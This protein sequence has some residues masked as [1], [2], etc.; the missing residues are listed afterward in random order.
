MPTLDL[1][2]QRELLALLSPLLQTEDER[3]ALLQLT[4]GPGHALLGR[5]DFSGAAE[6]F[7][8]KLIERLSAFG[9]LEPGKQ[10]LWAV[11]EI[12]RDRVGFDQQARIDALRA[13][14]NAP[15]A[16]LAAPVQRPPASVPRHLRVFLASPG[17][18]A[19]ERALAL[20]V[21]DELQYDPLLRGG[22]TVETVAWDKPGA[23]T[24]MLA[25]MTPQEA[26]AEGLP[27]PS[28][29]DI[30]VVTLWSR[31]GTP[32]PTD[33]VKSDGTPYRSATEWE[34][35]DA[36]QAAERTGKPDI[37]VYRRTEEL[38]LGTSDPKF[39][40]K[41][42]QWQQVE[43][44]FAEFRNPDGSIRRGYNGY[45]TPDAFERTLNLHLRERVRGFLEAAEPMAA[46]APVPPPAAA[47][48]PLWPDSPFPGLRAFTPDDAPI[49]FGRGAETDGLVQKLTDPGVRFL[50]VVGASGS[51]KSSLVAAGLLPR[52]KA[53][54][55]EGSKDSVLPWVQP[56]AVGKGQE[57]VG[58]RFTPAEISDNPF[59]ALAV[60]LAP[61]V[62]YQPR[63]LCERLEAAPQA[64]ADALES[65][66]AERP[67]WAEVLLFVDQ[68]E[69]LFTRVKPHY[70]APFVERLGEA[71]RAARVRV[72]VTLRGDFYGYCVEYPKLAERL[73][74]GSY[75]LAA[76][77]FAALFEMITAPANRAGLTFQEGLPLQILEDTGTAPGALALMGFALSELYLRR[78][79]AGQ[80]TRTAYE[81]FG[82][83]RGAIGMQAKATF[84]GLDDEAQAAFGEVFRE[85]VQVDDRGVATR[86]RASRA[87]LGK[88]AA[89]DRLVAALIEARLLV[90]SR[91]ER[92][93][94]LVEV[95]HEALF[96][97]W[98][99]L[100]DWIEMRRDDLRLLR[101]L[102]TAA[103]EWESQ[104]R[105][106]AFLWSDERVLGVIG[107]LARLQPPLT[108]VERDFLGPTDTK[109][110][111]AV[112]GHRG[113]THEQRDQIGVRLA[114]LDDLR[115][116]VR[117][118]S[119]GI[120]EIEWCS[121]PGGE[122]VLAAE[123]KAR[124]DTD[125]P[126]TFSVAPFQM[127]KYPITVAQ[128]QAF[129]TAPD[130][131]RRHFK[132]E[133]GR[134]VE[135]GNYP[136]VNVAW[137]EAMAFCVWLT[138]Q[139]GYEVRLATEWE[140]QQAASS[141]HPEN[142]YPWGPEWIE[143]VANTVESELGRAIAVGLYP[144]G[145]S[146]QGVFD[147]AGNIWEWCLNKYDDPTDTDLGGE[148]SRVVRGGAWDRL[149]DFARASLR[150]YLFHP[151]D[152]LFNIGFRVVCLP[153]LP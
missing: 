58:L 13:V 143:G 60:R 30:V 109:Q 48:L 9:E 36:L 39:L 70:R 71:I 110:M 46:P 111:L 97:A 40:E 141:G 136:A 19:D 142:H 125:G 82:G 114:L 77:G 62:Q 145:A 81:A 78:T 84:E 101:Q 49:F 37:L 51:G 33:W 124:P 94:A 116:G 89:A 86:Q 138:E 69:E 153:H 152:R 148:D 65:L 85:L 35:R 91:G 59:Q 121:I 79:D 131:H 41:Y 20:K 119:E 127:A 130:G 137:L 99:Q 50:A 126:Y 108:V 123:E 67:S 93:E 92:D 95:A 90:G 11:L 32:L 72:V 129:V 16:P 8:L 144:Q 88:S 112:L 151:F 147:L 42:A 105:P 150:S 133:P 4:V 107:M 28:E 63:A 34:Y 139:L 104:K 68:F 74:A 21:L 120:P 24:P 132:V 122:V 117:L 5:I 57:W 66:L 73:R 22:A 102:R 118:T 134:Q 10:A 83:V 56:S 43:A 98:P 3:R 38:N 47:P 1:T 54:A 17:D 55:I 45:P 23:G 29:C 103:A 7:V 12:A 52:L 27:K 149:Q 53:N 140:W 25:T 128:Y 113:T 61:L 80:L 31:I 76:P 2:T 75:P 6:P 96:S 14:V 135:Y 15:L 146:K 106:R 44:F 18:V 115:A 64:L 100:V 26:I 87:Q